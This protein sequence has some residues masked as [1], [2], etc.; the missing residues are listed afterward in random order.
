MEITAVGAQDR[1]PPLGEQLL[2]EDE[3][4]EPKRQHGALALYARIISR[5]PCLVIVVTAGIS[6]ALAA[7]GDN[8]DEAWKA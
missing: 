6:V 7:S 2:T 5:F 8:N 3:P 4:P 1:F